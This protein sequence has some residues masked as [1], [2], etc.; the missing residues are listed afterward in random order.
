MKRSCAAAL[1]ATLF[2]AWLTAAPAAAETLDEILDRHFAAVGGRDK[3]A[4]VETARLT[5][6]Q[7]FGP[8]EAPFTITWKRPSK[9]RLEFTLQGMTGIQAFDGEQAWMV[10]P[11]LGKTDPEAVTGD[12]FKDMEQQADLIEGSLFNWREKGHTVELVGKEAVE[13]TEAWKLKLTR[14][15]GDVSYVWLDAEAMLQIKAEGKRKR[16]D[17]E[18]EFESTMGD[19]KE[20][21][22]LM[23]PHSI[24]QRPKGAPQGMTI[25]VEKVELGVAIDDEIF[26]MPAPKPAAA[27]G[28][29]R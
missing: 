28:G 23:F 9:L 27:A 15:S 2:A 22:G 1:A 20:V 12:D 16:G 17:Q 10:M 19:Y 6:R 25:T 24:E 21:G 7:Q 13:G 8:Q 14:K 26:R 18:M 3:I 29:A 5:G 4:A 11:F